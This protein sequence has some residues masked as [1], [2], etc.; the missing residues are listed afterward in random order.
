MLIACQ[1]CQAQIS[2]AAA[3]CPKCGA[4]PDAFLGAPTSCAECAN[5]DYRP[6]HAQCRKCGA[7]QSVAQARP[8][9]QAPSIFVADALDAADARN[10]MEQ[11]TTS[12]DRGAPPREFYPSALS[13]PAEAW[14]LD[15]DDSGARWPFVMFSFKGQLNRLGFIAYWIVTY[16]APVIV[17]ALLFSYDSNSASDANR[18]FIFYALIAL[19][20]WIGMAAAA[21]RFHALDM[22][23]WSVLALFI[24]ILNLVLLFLLLFWPGTRGNAH[25][26]GELKAL[27]AQLGAAKKAI[28]DGDASFAQQQAAA[29]LAHY[30]DAFAGLQKFA[31]RTADPDAIGDAVVC[32]VRVGNARLLAGD[33][34]G[35]SVDFQDAVNML[36][37]LEKK[38]PGRLSDV[39]SLQRS[40]WLSI[41]KNAPYESNSA[42]A[43]GA[44]DYFRR[45]F[46]N[47]KRLSLAAPKNAGLQRDVWLVMW[48]LAP[49]A[50]SG[51]GVTW[52]Q[53]V[54]F[55]EIMKSRDLLTREDDA[56]LEAARA[57][58]A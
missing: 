27:R 56:F 40:A 48:R 3:A 24:P 36:R 55:M 52:Q 22:S 57:R 13:L 47:C 35:A 21:R 33:T 53:V 25:G 26:E 7:P 18:L 8:S 43:E 5:A 12:N 50:A 34:N 28:E 44:C 39:A 30:G 42:D 51:G 54:S 32:S 31:R 4:S 16:C 1:E 29:A 49:Y 58:A 15:A 45:Q 17:A 46:D 6:A 19:A 37:R 9:K 10:P 2:E 38:I 20:F 41:W 23:G 11:P 14:G